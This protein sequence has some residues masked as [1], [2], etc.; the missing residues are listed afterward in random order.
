MLELGSNFVAHAQRR[1]ALVDRALEKIEDGT[2]GLSDAS[3]EPITWE[4]LESMPEAIFTVAE[5][6]AFERKD[7]DGQ[8]T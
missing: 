7:P 2:Y 6:A 3:G 4:R 5:Q 8:G 1:L